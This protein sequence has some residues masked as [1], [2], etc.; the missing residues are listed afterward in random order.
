[1][2]ASNKKRNSNIINVLYKNKGSEIFCN[3]QLQIYSFTDVN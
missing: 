3:M 1:M 2:Q